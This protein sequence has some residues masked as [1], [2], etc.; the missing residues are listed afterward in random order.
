MASTRIDLLTLGSELLLGLTPNGHLAFIGESL[1]RRGVRLRRNVTLS[2]DPA[3]IEAEFRAAWAAAD[4]VITTGGLGPTVDDRTREIVAEV[5]GQP[6][7]LDEPSLRAIEERFVR[8]GRAMTPNN[9]R[10]AMRPRDFECLANPNG[11]APGLW[12]QSGGKVLAMLPGPPS[13]LQPMVTDQVLPRLGQLGLLPPGDTYVQLRTAGIG[14]SALEHKLLPFLADHPELD[15]A[16]CAH[17]G[18]VDVRL[19]SIDH[20]LPQEQLMGVA[21]EMA[22]LLG[23]DFYGF[24]HDS[25][26]K[27]VFERLR[28]HELLLAVAESCTGG[29][30]SNC[31]TDLPGASKVFAGGVVCYSNDAKVQMLDVP[32]SML[33]Q[34]GAVSAETAIAM[35]TGAA[36]RLGAD[37]ALAVT[38]FAGPGGGTAD[39][40]VGTIYIGLHAP[41][42]VWCRRLNYPGART[43]VKVRAVNAALDWLRRVL[44]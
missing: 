8:F 14:E 30:L 16:Y 1:A 15:V 43:Q 4:V 24:G 21:R 9:R 33:E 20:T 39:N 37:Y 19:A 23:E 11:T 7:V 44:G 35:A 36:E 18:A 42:G 31:F 28:Q 34:H 27:V 41:A 22:T 25:L 32:E 2:D 12:F 13:E 26:A 3:D 40:P 10:Q 17:A 29:L 38:G 6:L 5:L